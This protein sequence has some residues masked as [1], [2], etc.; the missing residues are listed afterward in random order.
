MKAEWKQ[1]RRTRSDRSGVWKG[2][3]QGVDKGETRGK[4]VRGKL[5]HDITPLLCHYISEQCSSSS[6]SRVVRGGW[7][8]GGRGLWGIRVLE[9]E[10][11]NH[12]WGMDLSV[13]K[14]H[15]I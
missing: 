6:M 7:S 2:A 11:L 14:P 15:I 10:F 3:S 5:Y 9:V 12:C 8:S 1:M 13:G 4:R